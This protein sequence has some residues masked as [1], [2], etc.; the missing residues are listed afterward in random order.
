MACLG[1]YV[2]TLNCSRNVIQHDT[3]ASHL[4]DALPESG[5]QSTDLPEI[6]VL[7]LQEI[8]P[9]AYAF[10][11]GSF[12]DPYFDAFR[13]SVSIAARDQHYANVVTK[14]VGMTAV[15]VF[16]RGDVAEN[17]AWVETAEVG[18]GV[19]EAGNK[20][21]A[22]VRIGYHI[23]DGTVDLTFVAAHLAPDEW[24]VARRNEDWKN[25]V[26]KLVFS[27][28]KIEGENTPIHDERNEEDVP[29]LQN[30]SSDTNG[31]IGL[32]SP[33]SY[34]FVAGDFNYR[35]SLTRPGPNDYRKF[36]RPTEDISSPH[37]YSHLLAKD[38]LTQELQEQRTL[39][40]LSEAPIKFL[41]TY[42]FSSPT[43]QPAP[44]GLFETWTW[45]KNRWP[46]WC[47][48]VLYQDV[49]P[50][51]SAG[52]G[53]IEVHRYDALPI[54]P[55]SDHRP[56][57]LSVS[58][59]LRPA[60]TPAVFLP[61]FEIDPNWE[62]KR[63]IARRKEVVVGVAAYLALTREGNVLLLSTALVLTLVYFALQSFRAG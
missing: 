32:Y 44:G 11:G 39:Q 57:A 53:G 7:S 45:A 29:L 19:H 15:M 3:L 17:I 8:A 30:E 18:V 58:V 20:G 50:S 27:R 51:T 40:H 1:V 42:K 60:S 31:D 24:A 2:L 4:F 35:T 41:P 56:V 54:I 21:A 13:R 55:T 36:P 37:H 49:P 14:N 9:I 59:P 26:Q 10:L 28:V 5:S 22:G 47:D 25:I 43:H 38:Q 23:R 52:Q 6:L 46:S 34:L 63:R 48:R 16:V 62:S 12:L 33:R 61:P